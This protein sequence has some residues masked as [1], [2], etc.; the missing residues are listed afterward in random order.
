MSQPHPFP[1]HAQ[2]K[3]EPEPQ[4][5]RVDVLIVG[6]GFGGLYAIYRM[7]ELGLRVR[8]IEAAS[9][10]GGTWFWNRYPGARCDVESLDYSYSFSNALQQEWSWSHRYAEQPEI[11]AYLNHVADRFD[12]RQHIRFETRVASM[13]WDE[14]RETWEVRT[15]HGPTVQA[16]YCIMASGNLS[17]PRVP[18]IP[19][20]E[21][22]QGEWHHSARWPEQGVDFSGKRVALIG[23]GAT[24]VQM[25]PKIAAQASFV[26]VFQRTAN[27]S[28]PARNYPMPEHEEREQK[29]NYPA[30]RKA[31]R[32]QASGMSRVA[33][34]TQSALD[35]SPE[36]R[37]R[38]YEQLWAK[39]GS[40]RMMG[41]FTDLLRNE[42]ANESLASFV[43]EK[44][45]A[46]VKDPETAEILTPRDHPI[47][48][49]RLCVDTD[50]YETFNRDNVKLVD[51]RRTPIQ[52]ITEKGLRTTDAEY[53]VDIIA[54]ATGFDAMTGA[55]NE[56]EIA[57]RGGE[58]LGHKWRAGPATYLGLMVHGFPN[59]FLVTGPG[60][61]SVKANMVTAIEQ[62]IEWIGDCL[63]YLDDNGI[64]TIEPTAQA[65]DAWVRH[66]NEVANGT[67]FPKA[68]NSWYVGANIPGKP[69]VFMPYVAGLP[70]YIKICEEVVADGYRGFDLRKN[71]VAME[72]RR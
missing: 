62:H 39:G 40:A 69:R 3:A 53:E 60:S 72:A 27:F 16:R 48:S 14:A 67:L 33:I 66:V 10:V 70:A 6:A 38:L 63:T 20:I 71:P 28:V 30:L 42:E 68:T 41:A 51:A 19:G 9:G 57:G 23:T 46:I 58:R 34:P 50:Y 31:A 24:G 55:L 64:A 12:L 43:R 59:M 61:P 45:R 18:D 4:P 13:R 52:E 37:L 21:R 56:I 36:E 26:T 32:K 65:E 8:C 11:L 35:L 44:I 25:L 2:A 1:R 29:A 54:F 7:R 49:R 22:F 47:G 5:E 15:D 17:A